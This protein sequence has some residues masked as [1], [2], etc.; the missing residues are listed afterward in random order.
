[1]TD[2]S[3]NKAGTSDFL[4][5]PISRRN[6]LKLAGI[7]GIGALVGASGMGGVLALTQAS[8]SGSMNK[9]GA[10]GGIVPFYGEHQAG[11]LTE[12]QNHVYFASFDITAEKRP[13]VI[14]LFRDWTAAAANMTQGRDV[15]EK[16]ANEY[17][18]PADT[19]E[20]A[21]LLPSNLTITFGVGPS[22]FLKD[23]VDRFGLGAKRPQA[24]SEL[25]VF[26]LDDLQPEWC[27]GD[28]CVQVC[29]D[30]PQVAFH[31]L[32]NL[33]RRARGI[34]AVR[35][36][37]A[38]FQR[39][40]QA[41]PK[42]ATPRNLFGF[43]DGTG[44]PDVND[45]KLMNQY[46]WVQPQDGPAWLAGGTYLVVRRIQMRIEVWDRT[47]LR[48]QEDTFGRHRDSGAPLGGQ[49]EFEP[50]DLNRKDKNGQ[51]VIPAT[52]HARIAHGDG[53][54]KLLRRSFS[55]ADGIEPKTGALNAGHLFICFQR[56]PARQFIPI[57]QNLA[58]NDK[59]NEYIVHRGSGIFACFPGVKQGSYLGE[60]LF[61]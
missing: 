51:L 46:V 53:Q 38:G 48:D 32:R 21:G 57:Q 7:G 35:W 1:M 19:G 2:E 52:A 34:A 12:V 25:P 9:A 61:S 15:A 23:G 58:K 8:G 20:A 40:H 6:M 11:I 59:L 50:L 16:L 41:D 10:A 56:D 14:D 3:R 39:T 22:F 43:K 31:A 18:P 33:T 44:N 13:E 42:K 45:P 27:G 4:T 30:D 26:P 36:T 17:V 29:A 24:L 5:Q 28:V 47:T 54:V 60:A 55:Y 49:D 37:Q